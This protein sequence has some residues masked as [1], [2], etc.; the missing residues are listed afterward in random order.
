MMEMIVFA[1][2]GIELKVLPRTKPP[3]L[4]PIETIYEAEITED[5]G[6]QKHNN[7]DTRNQEEQTIHLGK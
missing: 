5:S 2:D 7:R 3:M 1:K 4:E 6:A